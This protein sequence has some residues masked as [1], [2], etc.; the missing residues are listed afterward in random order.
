[1]T[2][3]AQA[4]EDHPSGEV[5]YSFT[6]SFTH[7]KPIKIYSSFENIKNIEIT[8][9]N[10]E[11]LFDCTWNLK[12]ETGPLRSEDQLKEIASKIIEEVFDLL[13][14][15]L[16]TSINNIKLKNHSLEPIPG[17][18]ATMTASMPVPRLV[19]SGRSGPA[20]ITHLQ[21]NYLNKPEE[22]SAE[23]SSIISQFSHAINRKDETVKFL[24]LY[25]LLW[26][27][28]SPSEVQKEVD[29]KIKEIRPYEK[30]IP[31]TLVTNGKSKIKEETIYTKLRN[32]MNHYRE[33]SAPQETIKNISNILH[34]FQKITHEIIINKINDSN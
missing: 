9:Q 4:I 24:L 20:P 17:K 19:A 6:M 3:P 12:I 15:K 8:K 26:Q 22:I 7:P 16:N 29:A 21:L 5:N 28:S 31:T 10:Q 33:H 11:D 1:M 13:T 23:N 30:M 25:K 14:I 32:E 34:E 27:I 2:S 18:G